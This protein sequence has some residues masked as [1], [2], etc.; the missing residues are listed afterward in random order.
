MACHGRRICARLAAPTTYGVLVN[1]RA[2]WTA[3]WSLGL[4][5]TLATAACLDPEEPGLL[6]PPTV[7]EDPALPRLD[8]TVAGHARGLHLERFGDPRRRRCSS[9]TARTPTTGTCGR[10]RSRSRI[11]TT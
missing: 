6:V 7:D 5:L 9:C 8:V 11:A 3:G 2:A 1:G 10:S 4:A